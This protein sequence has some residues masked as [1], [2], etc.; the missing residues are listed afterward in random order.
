MIQK[1]KKRY[2]WTYLQNRNRVTD[3]ENKFRVSKGER[4]G[5]DKLG[6]WDW[7]THTTILGFSG[8]SGGRESACNAGDLGL[9]SGLGRSPGEGNGKPLQYSCLQNPTDR[10][11]WQATVHRVTQSRTWLKQLRTHMSMR[12]ETNKGRFRRCFFT[13]YLCNNVSRFF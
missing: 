7:H 8:G 3:V 9:I 11:T 10:G 1:K 12:Q 5:R 4:G 6:G 2:K 13:G